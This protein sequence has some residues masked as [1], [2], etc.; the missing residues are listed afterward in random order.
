MNMLS[1]DLQTLFAISFLIELILAL[2]T[3]LYWQTQQIYQGVAAWTGA[4]LLK[5]L[6]LGLFFYRAALPDWADI[7]MGN[8]LVISV[9][10]LRYEALCRFFER[11][12]AW[13]VVRRSWL[14]FILAI[15]AVLAV[16]AKGGQDGTRGLLVMVLT[17]FYSGLFIWRTFSVE[18]TGVGV[19]AGLTVYAVPQ[20]LAAAAPAGA[21]AIQTGAVVKLVR[22]LMLGPVTLVLGLMHA[23]KSKGGK[24]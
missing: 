10:F 18:K 12:P 22:V 9:L 4:F 8:I 20:V 6:Y 24:K 23:D 16:G 15:G 2:M 13:F 3:L 5:A 21:T 14:L 11:R 17:C 7:G 19:I 1:F